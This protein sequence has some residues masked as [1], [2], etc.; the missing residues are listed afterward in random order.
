MADEGILPDSYKGLTSK[1][2][3][4]KHELSSTGREALIAASNGIMVIFVAYD[5]NNVNDK[6]AIV[7]VPSNVS[8]EQISALNNHL[9]IVNTDGACSIYYIGIISND[10][11]YN[12]IDSNEYVPECYEE[13][14]CDTLEKL[15]EYLEYKND[16]KHNY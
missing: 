2:S 4:Y 9:H 3:S 15:I 14:S 11:K 12:Q 7:Y 1:D 16:K 10:L 8:H 6:Y 13:L 5:E